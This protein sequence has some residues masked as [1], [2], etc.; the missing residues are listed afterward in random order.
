VRV[1]VKAWEEGPTGKE[2]YLLKGE[3]AAKRLVVDSHAAF[4]SENLSDIEL[5]P[6]TPK[7]SYRTLHETKLGTN[8]TAFESPLKVYAQV[9]YEKIELT[10]LNAVKDFEQDYTKITGSRYKQRVSEYLL[11]KFTGFR[12][13]SSKWQHILQVNAY[14]IATA[15]IPTDI[16]TARTA[17]L[18]FSFKDV[19]KFAEEIRLY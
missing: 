4:D 5:T 2:L 12:E 11:E 3:R 19:I 9:S 10:S 14:D 15:T 16:L 13:E 18:G 6:S 7:I 8:N 17:G 1:N